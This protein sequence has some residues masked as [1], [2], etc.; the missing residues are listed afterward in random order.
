MRNLKD[1]SQQEKLK[2]IEDSLNRSLGQTPVAGQRNNP[3]MPSF[4]MNITPPKPDPERD[5]EEAIRQAVEAGASKEINP[6]TG[7]PFY[8]APQPVSPE[9]AKR[10]EEMQMKADFLR[11]RSQGQ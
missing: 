6:E 9:E 2:L 4:D 5:A 1:L 8:S 3:V 7:M 10:R 11:R